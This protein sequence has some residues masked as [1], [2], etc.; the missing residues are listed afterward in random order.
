LKTN[1]F[2]DILVQLSEGGQQR[3][4][5]PQLHNTSGPQADLLGSLVD[6]A[7]LQ[8]ARNM[9]FT[10]S[11]SLRDVGL[12]GAALYSFYSLMNHSCVANSNLSI[13]RDLRYTAEYFLLK[14]ES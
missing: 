4:A 3:A 7:Q 8:A 1:S 11:K 2:T 10:N 12:N 5:H 13:S 6:P 14:P 9:V